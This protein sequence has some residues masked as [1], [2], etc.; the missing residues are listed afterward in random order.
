M[1]NLRR[2]FAFWAVVPL[3]LG[4]AGSAHAQTTP[5][6]GT[7]VTV[8]LPATGVSRAHQDR[9]STTP[10]TQINYKDC[11]TNDEITFSLSLGTGYS[12]Y[13]LEIWA[14]DACDTKLS[15]TPEA[16]ATCWQVDGGGQPNNINYTVTIK[17]QDILKGRTGGMSVGGSTDGTSGTGGTDATGGSGGGTD[18]GG[19]DSGGGGSGGG[20]TVTSQ[21]PDG[22]P[23]ECVL[24]S[25]A[26]A[27]QTVSV[28]FL[29]VNGNKD[30]FGGTSWKA[31][32]KLSASAP[33]D[34][35]SA[36]TGENIAPISWSYDT[37]N[38]D[39]YI[40]GY[41]FYC[42]PAPGSASLAD[43]G[44]VPDPDVVPICQDTT[45]LKP[46]T[47]PDDQ[48]KCGTAGRTATH[49]NATG[50]V[51]NV[52]YHVAVASTDTYLN[53]GNISENTCAVPQQVTGFFEAYRNAGGQ[54]GGGFCSFS[55]QRRPAVLFTV[56]GLGLCLMLRRRRAT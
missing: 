42:D 18:V 46:G 54:G 20:N 16:T 8:T 34:H 5:P 36:G 4:V 3:F 17:V 48:Y 44:I 30:S 9:V 24:T 33:P 43:A 40:N 1:F 52:A 55:P 29:L 23:P 22:A 50:L 19:T 51:N 25:A 41:Q 35:V 2:V 11:L 53:V 28:Y 49:G 26:V 21:P 15:R 39:T 27:P 10:I 13:A 12:Q 47:L 37:T 56:L 45:V 31:T 32:Y 7:S 6:T 14:G 38:V